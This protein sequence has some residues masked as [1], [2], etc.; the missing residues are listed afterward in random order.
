MPG[1]LY[2][3]D[4]DLCGESEEDL[5]AMVGSFA[6]VCRRDL[7]VNADNSK[8][9]F[10]CGEEGL[11]SEVCIDRIR[12]EHVGCVLDESST[13]EAECNRKGASERRVP[14]AIRSLVNANS[15]QPECAKVLHES[16]LVPVI[17]YGSETI[18]W[19]EKERSRIRAVLMDNLRGLL[20]IRRMDKLPNAQI[21]QYGGD[22]GCR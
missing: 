4:L 18:I 5:K 19:K 6:E 3:D 1:L 16:L 12:L 10:L 14:G 17:M 8:V 15:L 9:M 13:D 11:E 22:E 21:R 20:D 7:Q 2:A